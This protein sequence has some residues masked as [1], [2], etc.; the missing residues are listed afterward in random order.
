MKFIKK[1]LAGVAMLACLASAQASLVTV[2]GISWD[3]DSVVPADFQ[4]S[5]TLAQWYQT[6]GGY[7]PTGPVAVF[8][9]PFSLLNTYVTGAGKMATVNGVNQVPGDPNPETNPSVFAPGRE[10]TYTFGGI[11]ITNVT[12]DG[13]PLNSPVFTFDLTSSFFNVFSDSSKN[14]SEGSGLAGQVNAGDTDF[15]TPFL[16]GKFDEF[17]SNTTLGGAGTLNGFGNGLISV[18]GGAAF[19]NF[20]TDGTQST[21]TGLWSDLSFSGSS[22]IRVGSSMSSVATGEFQ[23]NTIPEPTSLALV[24]LALLGLGAASRARRNNG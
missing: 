8:G 13:N 10:M 11:K 3:P 4:A 23:G 12:W 15:A 5:A 22:Q 20:D 6:A 16:T 17:A 1:T 9:N 7:N 19:G 24:G 21:T 14:F 2:Q 18:T